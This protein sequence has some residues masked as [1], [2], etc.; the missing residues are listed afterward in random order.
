MPS[1]RPTCLVYPYRKADGPLN[2]ARDE[3]LLDLISEAVEGG[4]FRTYGWSLPTLSLGYF[5]SIHDAERS[6]RWTNTPLVRRP[7]GGG[8]LCHDRELTFA[9][10]V[11]RSHPQARQISSLYQKVHT[12]IAQALIEFGVS[13]RRRG[14]SGRLDSDDQPF[15]CFADRDAEDLVIGPTKVVGSAQRRRAGAVLLHGSILLQRSPLAP[16][17][18]GIRE[19]TGVEFDPRELAERLELAIPSGLGFRGERV[20]WT[21]ELSQRAERL[22]GEIYRNP[23]WTRRR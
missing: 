8:A 15:L 12:T 6:P 23:A 2:M 14:D 7:T 18:A 3:A 17:L 11:P 22:A 19:T 4:A 1:P 21:E 13:V 16:E 5:Q 10:V 9:V 20:D